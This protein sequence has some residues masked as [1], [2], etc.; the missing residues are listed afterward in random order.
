MTPPPYKPEQDPDDARLKLAYL[1]ARF[2][3]VTET[4][5]ARELNQVA[6][7]PGIDA[8]LFAL[9][10]APE[11]ATVH[12]SAQAWINQL[13]QATPRAG[14]GAAARWL[15]RR[16]L[17]FVTSLT[18]LAW[19]FRERPRLLP[20][21]ISAF[22]VGCAHAE[23][24]EREGFDH[25]HAH[26]VGNPGTAA[27][28]IHRLT[29]IGYSATVH[30]YELFQDKAFLARRIGE[31]RF[32]VTISDFN[33]RWLRAE[34]AG[35]GTP[36]HVI[37][38]GVDLQRFRFTERLGRSETVRAVTVG[39]LMPHKGQRVLLDAL[40]DPGLERITLAIIGEGD[41][42]EAL[43]Q[44]VRALG[45]QDRV[46]FLG[47][48]PEDRVADELE[49]SDL[50]ISPSLIGPTGRMEGVPVVLM[51][52][53]ASGVPA[54]ATRLSG[55]PE[56]IRDGETGLLSEQGDVASLNATLGRFLSDREA[57]VQRARAGRQLVEDEFDVA[58]SGRELARL[59]LAER[60]RTHPDSRP[61]FV[62]WS[63]SDRAP[64]LAEAVGADAHVVFFP[65][66]VSP[67]RVPLRYVASTAITF[68]FLLRRRPRVVV[69]TNPP[70]IPAT[71]AL[72]L[73]RFWGAELILDSHP[74]GFGLKGSTVGKLF[75]PL[76][77]YLIRHARATIVASPT[78]VETVRRAGGRPLVVHEAPPHWRIDS[79]AEIRGRP[80]ILWVS[81][82]ASDE[83]VTVVLEAARQLPECDFLITG[84]RR[85][86]PEDLYRSAPG[87]VT[88]TGFWPAEGFRHLI[89]SSS[90]LLVLTT[91]PASVPRAAFEAVE[92]LRP[93]V[94]S[95]WPD[96]QAIFPGAELVD[97]DP[98]DI[99]RGIRAVLSNFAAL[100]ANALNLRED[101]RARWQAQQADLVRVLDG[102]VSAGPQI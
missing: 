91:E 5:V 41:Q 30:A 99:A 71:L 44:H 43:E 100:N 58:N 19:G 26:F 23:T 69:A 81:I 17:R 24:M 9:F 72:L 61:A 11:S 88:F 49:Q 4:F 28:T 78:L 12:P 50:F 37:R 95:R 84:D 36:V 90:V 35:V 31:A 86:C 1:V 56:L 29:G 47:N 101:Q 66:L 82:F 38:A 92:G 60:A 27:W 13:R 76:H 46:S 62:A 89:E 79:M 67:S 77:R 94:L 21:S 59:F 53:L 74:R 6:S 52:A 102:A 70:I 45:L 48:L 14:L 96:L 51:E 63:R 87:N 15:R 85:R 34:C 97:N 54:I 7:D 93:L 25:I 3:K 10:P 16:P 20:A 68:A 83:P 8:H 42:R 22:I 18:A 32:V 33:A 98:E 2:P 80:T 40:A 75:A 39:S 64:E 65:S 55:V 73:G 57:G